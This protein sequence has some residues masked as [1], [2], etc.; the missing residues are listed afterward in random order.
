MKSFMPILIILN[1]FFGITCFGEIGFLNNGV[2]GHRGNSSEYPENTIKAFES[3]IEI[4]CDWIELDVYATKDGELLVVHDVDTARVSGRNFKIAETLYDELKTIDV[5]YDFR[6]RNKLTLK[7]CPPQYMPL[8]S[9]VIRLVMQQNKT[10]MSIQPKNKCVKEAVMLIRKLK[11]EKWVGFN[12]GSLPKMKQ[13]KQLEKCIPVFWDRPANSKI[14]DDINIALK[15]GFES[16]V[17]KH[18][19]ITEEKIDKVHKAKLEIGAWTVNKPSKLK[20]LIEMGVDRIYTDC[21]RTL[22]ELKK[23]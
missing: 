13:V 9:D 22:F 17:V 10:R 6:I 18:N 4:G 23:D 1:L 19:G 14:E 21:P 5:A 8:L 11:A 20:K 3:G 7:E 16:L 15:E 2:T 12:D